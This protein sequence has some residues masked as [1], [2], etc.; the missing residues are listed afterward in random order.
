MLLAVLS[1]H[2]YRS[3][4][5]AQSLHPESVTIQDSQMHVYCKN[6]VLTEQPCKPRKPCKAAHAHAQLASV[7]T[8]TLETLELD[9]R[10]LF[11]Q[12]LR[13]L[14]LAQ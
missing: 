12:G 10:W 14:V 4:T 9:A 6:L 2:L 11:P 1:G 3:C 8:D 5:A 7:S 13:L